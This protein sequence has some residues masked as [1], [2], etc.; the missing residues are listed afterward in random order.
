MEKQL[1]LNLVFHISFFH[2]HFHQNLF[3]KT[4]KNILKFKIL[5]YVQNPEESKLCMFIHVFL[6]TSTMTIILERIFFFSVLVGLSTLLSSI[7][8]QL[9]EE[10]LCRRKEKLGQVAVIFK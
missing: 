7:I 6:S 3:L 1:L 8:L 4:E 5:F 9:L 2:R 10:P